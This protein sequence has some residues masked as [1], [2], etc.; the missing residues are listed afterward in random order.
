MDYALYL[1]AIITLIF[2]LG[3]MVVVLWGLRRLNLVESVKPARGRTRR[4][5]VIESLAIDPKRRLLLIRRDGVEH[6]VMTGLDGATVIETGIV[7]AEQIMLP[8]KE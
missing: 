2:L 8:V 5:A 3:V 7:S 6:L 1:R 4:L